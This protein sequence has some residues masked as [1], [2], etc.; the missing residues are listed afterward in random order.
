MGGEPFKIRPIKIRPISQI[1]ILPYEL[2]GHFIKF[3]TFIFGITIFGDVV[4]DPYDSILIKMRKYGRENA[5]RVNVLSL[6]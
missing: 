3:L 4:K 1:I 6:V 2:F 5:V